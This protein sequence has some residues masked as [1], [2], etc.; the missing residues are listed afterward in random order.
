MDKCRMTNGITES[1]RTIEIIKSFVLLVFLSFTAASF[2]A[3]AVTN[4]TES[5]QGRQVQEW[6]GVV[7]WR[8]GGY[9]IGGEADPSGY[10]LRYDDKFA[11]LEGENIKKYLDKKVMVKGEASIKV[12]G[13][14]ETPL[15]LLEVIAVQEIKEIK[16][17]STGD[18]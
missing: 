1:K 18:K 16:G 14:I 8:D 10:I 12:A 5:V 17:D 13:G 9:A 3:D 6:T 11:Y 4:S 15:R 2:A 7:E